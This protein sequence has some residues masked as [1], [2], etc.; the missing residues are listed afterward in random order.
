MASDSIEKHISDAKKSNLF[1]KNNIIPIIAGASDMLS[2]IGYVS[3]RTF[4]NDSSKSPDS[5]NKYTATT[6]VI[7][8]D[9]IAITIDH[10]GIGT[11]SDF[12]ND[13]KNGTRHIVPIVNATSARDGNGVWSSI[14]SSREKICCATRNDIVKIKNTVHVKIFLCS[15]YA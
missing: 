2:S 5:V 12:I 15:L 1:L 4:D 11:F 9:R 7:M 10:F 13:T 6:M 8:L 3:A 14:N